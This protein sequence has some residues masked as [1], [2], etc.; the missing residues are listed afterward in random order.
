MENMKTITKESLLE[1]G[2]VETDSP[3]FPMRKEILSEMGFRVYV[4]VS[5]LR[6]ANELCILMSS[7]QILYINPVSIEELEIITKSIIAYEFL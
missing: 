7:T 4:C 6:N 5:T 1:F 2:M 3:I